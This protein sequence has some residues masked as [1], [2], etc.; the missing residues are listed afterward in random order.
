MLDKMRERT[1]FNVGSRGG[2]A[3]EV[4]EVDEELHK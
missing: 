3:P 4:D 2:I 1:L